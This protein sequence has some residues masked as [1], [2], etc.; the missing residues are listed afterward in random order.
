LPPAALALRDTVSPRSALVRSASRLT[1]GLTGAGGA[2]RVSMTLAETSLVPSTAPSLS[3]ASTWAWM[4]PGLPR[5][6]VG[7][8]EMGLEIVVP[9]F[10]LQFQRTPAGG[11]PPWS[12]ARRGMRSWVA[13]CPLGTGFRPPFTGSHIMGRVPGSST[14]AFTW[15]WRPV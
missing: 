3:R 9:S 10:T 6:T 1:V 14:Q 4:P 13:Y 2:S 5:E 7:V 8:W 11:L 15:N 12:S